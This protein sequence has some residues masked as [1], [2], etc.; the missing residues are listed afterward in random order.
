[1]EYRATHLSGKCVITHAGKFL[2]FFLIKYSLW[3]YVE[4][5]ESYHIHGGKTVGGCLA[6]ILAVVYVTIV[7]T[8]FIILFQIIY[9]RI[10]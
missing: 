1:M 5:N 6:Y 2:L 7:I 3:R 8:F 9:R 10:Y 4:Q